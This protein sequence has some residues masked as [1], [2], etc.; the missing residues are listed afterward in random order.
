M[1]KEEEGREGGRKEGRKEGRKK[2]KED[3]TGRWRRKT[4]KEEDGGT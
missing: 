3:D 4:V 2:R 1:T